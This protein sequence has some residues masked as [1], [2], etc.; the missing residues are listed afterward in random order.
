[1]QQI[2][3]RTT[4]TATTTTTVT[5]KKQ[6]CN[7]VTLNGRESCVSY[8]GRRNREDGEKAC[9]ALNGTFPQPTSS[10]DV[11]NLLS[12]L[13][14]FPLSFGAVPFYLD[15]VRTTNKGNVLAA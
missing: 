3:P 4:T 7:Q 13:P 6:V 14:V 10:S 15:M 9:Q 5:T 11:F 8:I 2:I 1:M 12:V